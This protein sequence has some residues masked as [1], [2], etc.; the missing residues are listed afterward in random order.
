MSHVTIFPPSA[1]LAQGLPLQ[2]R[3]ATALFSELP[4]RNTILR[5]HSI[6][7]STQQTPAFTPRLAYSTPTTTAN[8]PPIPC[9][10]HLLPTPTLST[11]TIRSW[12]MPRARC[13]YPRRLQSTRK[14]CP[15]RTTSIRRSHSRFRVHNLRVPVVRCHSTW[16]PLT[17]RHPHHPLLHHPRVRVLLVASSQSS[18]RTGVEPPICQL[19]YR[20]R[21][22]HGTKSSRLICHDSSPRNQHVPPVRVGRR[23]GS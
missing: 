8:T 12:T 3:Q 17:R 6:H 22:R 21:S 16:S 20:R 18:G 7:L 11:A 9:P 2:P 4:G 23:P 10:N 1:K 14:G 5:G 15:H 13:P 19:S